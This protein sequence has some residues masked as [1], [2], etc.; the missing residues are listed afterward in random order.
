M[1]YR[2]TNKRNLQT[3]VAT[4]GEHNENRLVKKANAT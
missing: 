1:K 3:R 4:C 2:N